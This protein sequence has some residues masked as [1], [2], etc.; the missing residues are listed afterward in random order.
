MLY[1]YETHLHTSESSACG[2]S[3]ARDYVAYYQDLG[4]AGLFVTDHFFGG[5]TNVSRHLPW[6]ERVNLFCRGYETAYN[7]G[8]RRGLQV[9]F[10]WEQAYRGDEY[11]VYGLPKAWLYEHPEVTRWTRAEQFAQASLYGACVVQAHP[12]RNRSYIATIRLNTACVHGAEVYNAA[13]S[14]G[15]NALAYRYAKNLGLAMLAGADIHSCPCPTPSGVAF[16]TPLADAQ[17]FAARVRAHAPLTL[18]TPADAFAAET[19]PTLAL[20]VE[21]LGADGLPGSTP[22]ATLL[23]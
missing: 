19:L 23:R 8:L 20:P 7:E 6:R 1:R 3:S 5:N 15:E 14:Q 21:V 16:A 10:G 11:L 22:L 9:L 13:N 17:D 4:Y 2:I 18:L 12:F